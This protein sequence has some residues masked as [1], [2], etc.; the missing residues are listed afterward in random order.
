MRIGG[1]VRRRSSGGSSGELS[2]QAMVLPERPALGYRRYAKWYDGA[3]TLL[4]NH[5]RGLHC[6][7]GLRSRYRHKLFQSPGASEQYQFH[8]IHIYP[9]ANHDGRSYHGQN[10]HPAFL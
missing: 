8:T 9:H 7:L 5:A 2:I 1:I 10:F 4:D 3:D 6:H